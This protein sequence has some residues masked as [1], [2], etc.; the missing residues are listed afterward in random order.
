MSSGRNE[1]ER[2]LDHDLGVVE[3]KSRLVVD[4]DESKV[5]SVQAQ[6]WKIRRDECFANPH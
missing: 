1:A 4:S 5:G 3:L 2:S 6:G